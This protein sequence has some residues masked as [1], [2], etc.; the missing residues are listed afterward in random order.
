MKRETK[1]RWMILG[2]AMLFLMLF[3]GSTSPLFPYDYGW[4]SALFILV[5]KCLNQGKLL[6]TDIFD[7]KGPI[8]FWIEALG[9]KL[10]VTYGIFAV[11][12]LFMCLTLYLMRCIFKQVL[13]KNTQL[14]ELIIFLI[15]LAYPFANGNLTEEYSL[16]F[17]LIPLYLAVRRIMQGEVPTVKDFLVYG[18]CFGIL[19]FIR[20]NNAVTIAGIV[21][22]WMV[23]L[24]KHRQHKTLVLDLAAGAAGIGIVTVPIILYFGQQGTLG[25]MLYATFGY[26]FK[27]GSNGLK[28]QLTQLG[29]PRYLFRQGILYFP[30]IVSGWIY[31]KCVENKNLKRLLVFVLISNAISLLYGRGYNHYFMIAVPLTGIAAALLLREY[32]KGN[33]CNRILQSACILVFA[34]YL[35]LSMRIVGVNFYKNY[36]DKTY[37]EQCAQVEE[38]FSHIPEGEKGS[39]IGYNIHSRCYLIGNVYPDYKYYTAQDSWAY[40]NPQILEDFYQYLE[41]ERPMWIVTEVSE[42]RTRIK[43]FLEGRYELK[44]EDEYCRYYRIINM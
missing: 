20:L 42:G 5:G 24:L 14:C 4:D 15:F 34:G 25:D 23:Y 40:S 31:S 2:T 41:Q 30:L 22:Y 9:D 8:I 38:S 32:K 6:Y 26:N 1:G 21:L 17:I 3:S 39:I 18:I 11:Q 16:V 7:H 19:S 28:S 37:R 43:E 13:D 36:I 10:H 44:M 12:V 35:F 29:N 27:Y 33:V